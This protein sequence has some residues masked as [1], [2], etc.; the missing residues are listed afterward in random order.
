ML[1][2]LQTLAPPGLQAEP[3]A[4]DEPVYLWPC[5]AQA[6]DCW[7]AVQTQW[8]SSME[9]HTGLDY[10]GVRAFLDLEIDDPAQRRQV[11]A[12]IRACEREMLDIWAQ[13]RAEQPTP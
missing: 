8:R 9:G 2:R 6:W 4:T 3:A 11:F 10:T 1:A 12:G 13:R 5:N 7:W